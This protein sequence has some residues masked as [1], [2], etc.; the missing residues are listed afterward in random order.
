MPRT[1]VPDGGWGLFLDGTTLYYGDSVIATGVLRAIG[2]TGNGTDYMT[3]M[4]G[5]C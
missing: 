1:A 5:R 2:G 4:Q 3:Y